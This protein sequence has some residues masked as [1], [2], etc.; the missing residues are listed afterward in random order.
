MFLSHGAESDRELVAK[1]LAPPV[2]SGHSP[3]L[4]E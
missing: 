2:V 1:L 4:D 3:V